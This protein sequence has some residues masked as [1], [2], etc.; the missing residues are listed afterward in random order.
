MPLFPLYAPR[1]RDNF[2]CTFIVPTSQAYRISI[3]IEKV[4]MLF[5]EILAVCDSGKRFICANRISNRC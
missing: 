2:T 5:R 4:L 3:I 1:D